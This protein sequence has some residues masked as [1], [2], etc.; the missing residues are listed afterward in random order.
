MVATAIARAD[1]GRVPKET[2][3]QVHNLKNG[4]EG[5]AVEWD[6]EEIVRQLDK[7]MRIGQ[8]HVGEGFSGTPQVTQTKSIGSAG[9]SKEIIIETGTWSS[10]EH[11]GDE[12]DIRENLNRLQTKQANVLVG[13]KEYVASVT[14]LSIVEEKRDGGTARNPEYQYY[15]KTRIKLQ[16]TEL[17]RPSAALMHKVDLERNLNALAGQER[18]LQGQWN[19][20]LEDEA[21]VSVTPQER[22]ERLRKLDD[23]APQLT[24]TRDQLAQIRK[25]LK[26]DSGRGEC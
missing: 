1:P 17:A 24:K 19:M 2:T 14:G 18:A 16:V 21:L 4:L 6:V 10:V 11:S 13:G 20:I 5:M 12:E 9:K 26:S 25:E 23:I 7:E 3:E 8:S 22:C 15:I